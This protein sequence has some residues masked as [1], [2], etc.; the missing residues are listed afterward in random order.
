MK[1][2]HHFITLHNRQTPPNPSFSVF[3]KLR[4]RYAKEIFR[5]AALTLWECH[6]PELAAVSLDAQVQDGAQEAAIGT[7]VELF[8][9]PGNQ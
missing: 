9:V 4:Y 2:L 7:S 3:K 6:C 5:T 1:Q 8:Q